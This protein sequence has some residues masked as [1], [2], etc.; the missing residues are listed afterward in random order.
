MQSIYI[1][2]SRLRLKNC[3][4]FTYQLVISMSKAVNYVYTNWSFN[5]QKLQ[6]IYMK[7]SHLRFKR[8]KG[9]TYKLVIQDSK[10]AK[11][12]HTK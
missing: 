7:T 5:I 8:Y 3:K 1:K 4:G 11:D 12:L 2:T 9:F 10:G 6:K